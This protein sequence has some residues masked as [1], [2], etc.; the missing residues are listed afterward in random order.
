MLRI[1]EFHPASP[2]DNAWPGGF[3]RDIKES[4]P[5]IL[6]CPKFPRK[7]CI[8]L[9]LYFF[10]KKEKGKE[11]FNINL[12]YDERMDE[13]SLIIIRDESTIDSFRH[14]A[15]FE[16]IFIN[17]VRTI[18]SRNPG[19]VGKHTSCEDCVN[20]LWASLR[21]PVEKIEIL[22]V[23][24]KDIDSFTVEGRE[25][26][27]V[28]HFCTNSGFLGPLTCSP[29][30]SYSFTESAEQCFEIFSESSVVISK[31]FATESTS[32][33]V[34]SQAYSEEVESRLSSVTAGVDIEMGLETA[35]KKAH[36]FESTTSR[37]RSHKSCFGWAATRTHGCSAEIQIDPRT[38][39]KVSEL[40]FLFFTTS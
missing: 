24:L 5:L 20:E 12:D 7:N 36:G 11:Y 21:H 39:Q 40:L 38:T 18:L 9:S 30:L 13:I 15:C 2:E 29:D 8:S 31:D 33:L 26:Q 16:R 6:F 37:G 10:C 4:I 17:G 28:D 19:W 3:T 25:T 1:G 14:R 34:V 22:N 23:R 32:S 35:F 27:S